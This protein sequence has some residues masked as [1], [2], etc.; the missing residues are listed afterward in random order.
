MLTFIRDKDGRPDAQTGK[1]DDLLFSEMIAEGIRDQQTRIVD[2]IQ[3]V[4]DDDDEE[5]DRR[6]DDNW[7]N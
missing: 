4:I 6:S 1:H 2:V 7:F 3:T 5:D